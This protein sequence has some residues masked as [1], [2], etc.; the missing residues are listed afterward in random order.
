MPEPIL[1]DRQ[2]VATRFVVGDAVRAASEK[3]GRSYPDLAIEVATS[4][5]G[6]GKVQPD[7]YFRMRMF[8]ARVVPREQLPTFVGRRSAYGRIKVMNNVPWWRQLTEDKLAFHA[9][10]EGLGFGGPELV[11]AFH[12]FRTMGRKVRMLHTVDDLVAFLRDPA[13][14]PLFMKPNQLRWSMGSASL[15]STDGESVTDLLGRVSPIRVFAEQVAQMEDGGGFLFQRTQ[16]NHPTVAAICG[17]ALATARILAIRED[18]D[19]R[20]LRTHIKLPAGENVADNTWRS[21]NLAVDVDP[22][23][24]ALGAGWIGSGLTAVEAETHPD[25]GVPLSGNLPDWDAA[26]ALVT[27]AT[28][29]LFG[30][31]IVGW[32]VGFTPDG[33]VLIEAN[34]DPDFE[35]SQRLTGRGML[36]AA[37]LAFVER[38]AAN[39]LKSPDV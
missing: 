9:Y 33:P 14:Y 7:E 22:A 20:I 12:P 15:V 25:T 21:G 2:Q 17:P 36:D 19:V 1:L 5:F 34:S 32:D 27:E 39:P 6:Q 37:F 4:M 35:V 3:F 16:P 26:I 18:G 24:G 28:R 30:I 29:T 8:D 13:S 31:R 11:A 23:N 10:M 38:C